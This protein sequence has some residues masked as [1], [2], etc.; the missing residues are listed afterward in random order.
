[1]AKRRKAADSETLS[2]PPTEGT[3]RRIANLLAAIAIK[4]EDDTG[5]IKTLNSA[6]YDT[7]EIAALLGKKPNDISVAMYRLR[8][9]PRGRRG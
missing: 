4:G 9:K 8:K 7:T 1:M 2:G 6:G 3:L 5:K